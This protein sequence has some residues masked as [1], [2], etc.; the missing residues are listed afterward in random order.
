[1]RVE[2]VL[3]NRYVRWSDGS[4]DMAIRNQAFK[5]DS[6]APRVAWPRPRVGRSVWLT[7]PQ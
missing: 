3:G 4:I 2:T 6:G 7:V 5:A 1:M